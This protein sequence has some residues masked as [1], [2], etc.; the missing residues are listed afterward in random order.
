MPDECS[1]PYDATVE[2]SSVANDHIFLDEDPVA[3]GRYIFLDE[4]PVAQGRF[5]QSLIR[6]G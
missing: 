6:N 1:P 2:N 5:N 3:Q 4:D